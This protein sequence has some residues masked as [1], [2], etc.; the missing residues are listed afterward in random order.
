MRH[1]VGPLRLAHRSY[2]DAIRGHRQ[3]FGVH[4]SAAGWPSG[5]DA[6]R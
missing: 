6:P 3:V 5:R 4:P 2:R 1:L